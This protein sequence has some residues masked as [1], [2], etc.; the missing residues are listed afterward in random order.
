MQRFTAS[1]PDNV[2]LT[3]SLAGS[4]ERTFHRL[5]RQPASCMTSKHIPLDY[6]TLSGH[7]AEVQ[8]TAT[9]PD[10]ET[11]TITVTITVT[12]ECTSADGEPPCAPG[13]PGA[14]SA[15]DTSLRVSWSAPRTPSGTSITGYDLQYRE[16]GQRGELDSP[17]RGRNGQTHPHH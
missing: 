1:H 9:A 4:D 11:A 12:D 5:T 7:Q 14:S 17:E 2:N 16:S 8:I 3:Y 15:S 10:N 13:R 6:E